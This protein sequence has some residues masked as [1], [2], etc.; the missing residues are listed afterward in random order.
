MYSFNKTKKV[1]WLLNIEYIP[2]INNVINYIDKNI[3][4]DLNVEMLA[5]MANF[6][7]FY[8][9]RIF[10]KYIGESIYS[11]IKRLRTERSFYLLWNSNEPIKTIAI[12]CGFKSV[13]HF[14]YNYKNYFGISATEQRD[15]NKEFKKE[16]LSKLD[17]NLN[18][19]VKL[20]YP[21]HWL[22]LKV[23]VATK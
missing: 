16:D 10:K 14:S 5:Q 23:L 12:K 7:K 22:F 21:K 8:F 4:K 3:Y 9:C 19:N 6:S 1:K 17:P 15:R 13:S 11:Y 18:V 20:D 2:I